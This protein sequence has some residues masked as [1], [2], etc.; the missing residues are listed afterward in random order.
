MSSRR[1]GYF[2]LP[3]K[4]FEYPKIVAE[5]MSQVMILDAHYSF[6]RQCVK[7]LAIG[8]FDIVLEAQEAYFYNIHCDTRLTEKPLVFVR[9]DIEGAENWF[10]KKLYNCLCC[11]DEGSVDCYRC[12]GS[13]ESMADGSKCP[14]C[15]GKGTEPCH[16][17]KK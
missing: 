13:G 9:S 14:T 1:L 4:V 10:E 11:Y 2:E 12:R 15:N 5:I 16:M 6:D 8:P 17:C 3:E 7:Y